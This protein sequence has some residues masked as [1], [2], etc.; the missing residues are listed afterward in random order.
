M[1]RLAAALAG[2]AVA[3]A[4]AAA[5]EMPTSALGDYDYIRMYSSDFEKFMVH[6]KGDATVPPSTDVET[7]VLRDF[8]KF[9]GAVL[10]GSANWYLRGYRFFRRT[11]EPGLSDCF[12]AKSRWVREDTGDAVVVPMV[13]L[14]C[15]EVNNQDDP[16]FGRYTFTP[17][18]TKPAWFDE[19]KSYLVQIGNGTEW[20]TIIRVRFREV[21]EPEPEPE[22]PSPLPEIIENAEEGDLEVITNPSAPLPV[23]GGAPAAFA[24]PTCPDR[25]EVRPM[26]LAE[27]RGNKVAALSEFPRCQPYTSFQVKANLSGTNKSM[28]GACI[29]DVPGQLQCR[30]WLTEKGKWRIT[31]SAE[32]EQVYART[33]IVS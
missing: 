27:R 26:I 31:W 16:T 4:P 13:Q 22:I 21:P 25:S 2:L 7:V 12:N 5:I 11:Y 32:N 17:P 20:V 23:S 30:T 33:V 1:K 19:S 18:Q 3:A 24:G 28:K 14:A 29:W 15:N 6:V 8:R 10:S 9:D